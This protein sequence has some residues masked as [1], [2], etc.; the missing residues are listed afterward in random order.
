VQRGCCD[1]H[2]NTSLK[3]QFYGKEITIADR[4]T[5][6]SNAEMILE[7]AKDKTVAFLV[8]GDPYGYV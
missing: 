8:V 7:A 2:T 4:E 3:E 5:V 6:E 1:F